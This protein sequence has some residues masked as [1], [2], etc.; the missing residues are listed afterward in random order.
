MGEDD[1]RRQRVLF[2]THHLPWPPTSGG[3]LR[4]AELLAR[5][6]RQFEVEL[7]A[8]SKVAEDDSRAVGEAC[9]R[10]V[11]ARVFAAHI[12]SRI[13]LSPHVRRHDSDE[14]RGYLASWWPHHRD[15][16]VHVEG[17]YLL[18]LLPPQ[19]RSR[20]LVVEHNIESTLFDQQAD[21]ERDPWRRRHLRRAAALTRR[22]ERTAWQTAAAVGAITPED[23]AV[24]RRNAPAATVHLLPNGAD[25]LHATPPA[26]ASNRTPTIDLLFIGNFAYRPSQ[27]AARWLLTKIFPAVALRRPSATLAF[28][29]SAPPP[30]LRQ[31]A[32]DDPR[33]KVTGHVADLTA[34]LDAAEVVVCPLRIG[35]GIKVKILE[36]LSRGRAVVTTPVGM[37]GLRDLPPGATVVREDAPSIAEACLR[38][39]GSVGERLSQ[40]RRARQAAR[41]L[42]T[43]DQAAQALAG[44]WGLLAIVEDHRDV[45]AAPG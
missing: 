36:A 45:A 25:H 41:V 33:L 18:S 16:A 29:G 22:A 8:I 21:L 32:Q 24:V 28:V 37:Q 13:D 3:R 11:S 14:A 12:S 39:L 9:S 17:H 4:E 20:A 38:L 34:W 15:V 43:W 19:A 26:V 42:P 30:W 23:V 1:R 5:L 27:D 7:V 40:Q 31:A 2:L 35:G 6:G 44:A 10:G